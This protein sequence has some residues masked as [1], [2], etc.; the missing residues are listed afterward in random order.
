MKAFIYPRRHLI[1]AIAIFML[2]VGAVIGTSTVH[3]L[4]QGGG[5]STSGGC[6]N[7]NGSNPGNICTDNGFGWTLY[8]TDGSSGTP[9]Y[10]KIDT[11]SYVSSQCSYAGGVYIFE[12]AGTS[13]P[14][15]GIYTEAYPMNIIWG[16]NTPGDGYWNR[17]YTGD[18]FST[19]YSRYINNLAKSD[20]NRWDNDHSLEWFCYSD[21]PPW[22]ISVSSQVNKTVAIPGETVTWTPGI[23]NNGNAKTNQPIS[24]HYHD[25]GDWSDTGST[26]TIGPN[27]PIGPMSLVPST[28]SYVVR[29]SDF[30][31]TLCRSTV[32]SPQSNV[33]GSGSIDSAST[34]ATATYCV[35]VVRQPKVDIL[36]G[37]LFVGNTF[38]GLNSPSQPSNVMTSLSKA[39]IFDPVTGK[40]VLDSGKQPIQYLFGSWV[41]YGIFAS[42]TANVINSGTGT[43]SGSAFAGKGLANVTQCDYSK[44]T[45]VN[46]TTST[47]PVTSCNNNSTLGS[48]STGQSIPNIAADFP[49]VTTAGPDK[50]PIYND[51]TANPQGVYTSNDHGSP[52]V[53]DPI[54][55]SAKTFSR[56]EWAVIN[57]PNADVT[58]TGD[59]TYTDGPYQTI[60]DI[61][62]LIIIAKNIYINPNVKNV[63]AWLIAQGTTKSGTGVLDTCRISSDYTTQL[64]AGVCNLPLQVNGPIMCQHLWLRRTY[65][66]DKDDGTAGTPA[67]T[68]NLRPDA[69]LW[70][71]G[72]ASSTGQIHTGYSQ[73]L[74]PRF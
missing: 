3:G 55:I 57:A 32:A 28:S 53:S 25:S 36:G 1:S 14:V 10:F 15:S 50:T 49:V 2:V 47:K 30:G 67:E 61:P 39:A 22:T 42:G 29:A 64:T 74:P 38:D 52:V 27:Q 16:D 7:I 8:K 23:T 31:K 46:A 51:A 11:W 44:L 68:F 45:F 66:L 63:D 26:A 40:P 59:I 18:D 33:V 17:K 58:I 69:Y 48:Y 5:T 34:D 24:W 62:Q 56:G 54:T 6:A 73:E 4:N 12:V 65:G 72:R 60:Y 35:T 43:G 20:P 37:D 9:S 13:K 71:F 21:N 70:S 41:E 19:V